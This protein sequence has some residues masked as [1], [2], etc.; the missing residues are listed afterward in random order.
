MLA[1]LKLT[2]L[3]FQGRQGMVEVG[4]VRNRQSGGR[5]HD[6]TVNVCNGK[7]KLDTEGVFFGQMVYNERTR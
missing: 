3:P 1:F 2:T 7:L 5:N 4:E 6:A